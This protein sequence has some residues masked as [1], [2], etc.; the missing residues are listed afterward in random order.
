MMAALSICV[1]AS[2]RREHGNPAFHSQHT[3]LSAMQ[4]WIATRVNALAMTLTESLARNAILAALVCLY[5]LGAVTPAAARTSATFGERAIGESCGSLVNGFDFDAAFQCTSAD[6]NPTSGI[7]Q[8]APIVLGTVTTPPY[9]ATTCDAN[10]AGMIQWTGTAFQGCDGTSWVSFSGGASSAC[11]A[12]DAFSFTN[13]T[14][15]EGYS[16]ITSNTVT[17][18]GSNFSCVV[19]SS[20]TGCT[21]IVKNGVS[22][23]ITSVTF[24][25]GDTIALKLLSSLSANT[26]VT[27]SVTVGQT[28]ATTW[29]VTT[30]AD[31]CAGSPAVGAVCIDGTVYA[32]LSPDGNVKMY[33]TRCD[34]GQTWSGSACTGT[35]LTKTWNNGTTNWTTTGY[36]SATTGR[37]N[38]TG[39][40]ALSDAGSPHYAAQYCDALSANGRSDWYLPAKDELNVMYTNKTAIGSFLVDGTYY[41]SSSEYNNNDAWIQRFSDGYQGY[42]YKSNNYLVRC[43]RR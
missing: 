11:N 31:A 24:A 27:A 7:K 4:G 33:T 20:C 40:A 38:T 8:V 10:K 41:W 34:V 17:L 32:G 9:A 39:I 21:D 18:S 23:G 12:P 30:G 14:G 2:D 25:P 16:T 28:A 6:A 37:A 1:I 35:R 22:S 15:V 13:Q 29:S 3:T 43:A 26:A 36:T 19:G 42:Y 5:L